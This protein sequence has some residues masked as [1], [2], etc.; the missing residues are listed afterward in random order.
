MWVSSGHKFALWFLNVKSDMLMA[1]VSVP[2]LIFFAVL[3]LV[4][5]ILCYPLV[6]VALVLGAH[7]SFRV[8]KNLGIETKR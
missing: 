8:K 5:M 7:P 6:V 3:G 4:D 2:V 1:F